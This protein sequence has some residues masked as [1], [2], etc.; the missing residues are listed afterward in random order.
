M[1]PGPDLLG[2]VAEVVQVVTH[3][4]SPTIFHNPTKRSL[5]KS[6]DVKTN[7]KSFKYK[8]KC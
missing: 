3:K 1:R 2:T 7:F 8:M 4:T 6:D 5:P